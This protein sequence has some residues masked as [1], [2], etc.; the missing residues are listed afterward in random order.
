MKIEN[1]EKRKKC[2]GDIV[3]R[4]LS[5]KFNLD[6]RSGFRETL[7]NGRRTDDGR[8]R[9]DSRSADKVKQS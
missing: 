2:P 3:D 5:I 7:V 9:H 8:L 4:E 6:P 1:F